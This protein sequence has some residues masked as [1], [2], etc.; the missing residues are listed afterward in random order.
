MQA[1]ADF[2]ITGWDQAEWGEQADGPSLGKA[3]VRKAFTGQLTGESV[4]EIV[5]CQGDGGAAYCGIER[6]TGEVDGRQ[7]SF[8]CQH[9]AISGG[10]DTTARGTVVPGS[11]TGALQ[12]LSGTVAITVLPDGGH[13][14]T[15]DYEI[16]A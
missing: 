7:G 16:E 4:A 15:L 5:T 8:V 2:T 11:G 6:F 14:F 13:T 3:T 1:K 9:G 12:G 10:D